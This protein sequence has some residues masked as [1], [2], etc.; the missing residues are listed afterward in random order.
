MSTSL[1]ITHFDQHW[2]LIINGWTRYSP[3]LNHFVA[4]FNKYAVEIWAVIFLIMWFWPPLRQTRARRAVIYA[5]LAGVLAVVINLA[6]AHVLPYRPRPFV[7]EPQLIH[8]LVA[9]RRD[10]SFPSTHAAGSFG[11]AVGLFY[12]GFSDGLW[13]LLLAAAIAVARVF[14][15]LHWPTDVL[16]GAAVGVVS[17]VVVLMARGWVE[18]LVKLLFGIFGM[19]PERDYRRHT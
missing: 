16:A 18:W 9:H 17:G 4:D 15:G 8:Q 2:E 11:I 14:A 12:A 19:K 5:V 1:P 7:Y 3:L 10:T 6:I 13:A